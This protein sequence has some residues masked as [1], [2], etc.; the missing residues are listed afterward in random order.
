LGCGP[1][2]WL[3]AGTLRAARHAAVVM[4]LSQWAKLNGH[5]PYA[6]IRDVLARLPTHP[7]RDI[8]V[9][10]PYRGRH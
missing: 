2:T 4:R 6:C 10:P 1:Q 5:D 3:L 9:L 7:A 8:G